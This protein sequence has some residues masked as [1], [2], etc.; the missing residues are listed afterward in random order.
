LQPSQRHILALR[1]L[2]HE[3]LS[4]SSPGLTSLPQALQFGMSYEPAYICIVLVAY[5]LPL[6]FTFV[7]FQKK[8]IKDLYH[9]GE[10][11][12]WVLEDTWLE[13]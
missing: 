1:H 9:H 6:I 7:A 3:K 13:S 11:R 4:E 5:P 12:P 2:G 10:F 8:K